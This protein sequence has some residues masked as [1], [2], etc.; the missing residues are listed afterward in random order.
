MMVIVMVVVV[1]VALK[2]SINRCF[3]TY[4]SVS[5]RIISRDYSFPLWLTHEY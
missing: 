4:C 1:T 2:L 5:L 3:F